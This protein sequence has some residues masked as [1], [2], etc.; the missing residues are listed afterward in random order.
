MKTKNAITQIASLFNA[1]QTCVRTGHDW[2]KNHKEN[3]N[4]IVHLIFPSG[5][6]FDSGTSFDFDSS[7]DDRLVFIT[8]FHHMDEH[9]G[10]DGWTRHNVIV[11][12]SLMFG[13]DLRIT[14]KDRNDI[15]DY[16]H[17]CFHVACDQPIKFD[18]EKY[19]EAVN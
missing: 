1:Y 16:I 8:D 19:V 11:T 6:G 13:F 18:G 9:G 10:Y 17:E 4:Q 15:K 14:G 7:K 5:S 2:A 3:I 12:P